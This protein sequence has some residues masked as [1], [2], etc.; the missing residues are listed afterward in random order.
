MVP[1]RDAVASSGPN[2]HLAAPHALR[3]HHEVTLREDMTSVIEALFDIRRDVGRIVGILEEDDGEQG[4][5][6]EDS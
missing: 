5:E 6:E 1:R 3:H 4:D 2:S